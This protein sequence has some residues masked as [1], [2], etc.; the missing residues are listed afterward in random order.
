MSTGP[1]VETPEG[2][3]PVPLPWGGNPP[4]IPH[5]ANPL[6]SF[7]DKASNTWD[8]VAGWT[9]SAFDSATSFLGD[10]ASTSISDVKSMIKTA[11]NLSQTNWS[12]WISTVEDWTTVSIDELGSAL[13]DEVIRARTDAITLGHMIEALGGAVYDG[14]GAVLA[15]AETYADRLV[16]GVLDALINDIAGVQTWAIDNIAN[17]LLQEIERAQVDT[18][19]RVEG[20]IADVQDWVRSELNTET[21]E[22]VLAV[23]GVAAAVASIAT[24]VDECGAPMCEEVGPNSDFS[25]LWKLL[26]TSALLAELLSLEQETFATLES[27][28]QAMARKLVGIAEDFDTFFVGGSETVGDVIG[29]L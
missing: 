20:A 3:I 18:L 28:V 5:I 26:S 12:T 9:T 10:T 17:P 8:D 4:P 14:L 29:S 7:I 1:V 15:G 22:R 13:T 11:L 16:N 6:P 25:K 27:D 21:A 24:W 23:A 2:P 19:D